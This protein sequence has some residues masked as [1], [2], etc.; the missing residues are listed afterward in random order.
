MDTASGPVVTAVGQG[1]SFCVRKILLEEADGRMKLNDFCNGF[2]QR[3]GQKCDIG[4]LTSALKDY[5]KVRSSSLFLVD[6]SSS[7]VSCSP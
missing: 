6:F 1:F 2:M 3:Y 5:V 4:Q 7:L